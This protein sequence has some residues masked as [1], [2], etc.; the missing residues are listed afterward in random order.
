MARRVALCYRTEMGNAIRGMALAM[1]MTVATAS[2]WA[3]EASYTVPIYVTGNHTPTNYQIYVSQNADGSNAVPYLFD[4]GSP[5][6][7]TVQGT[8]TGITPTDSF[9]FG[10]G[11]PVYSYYVQ[12]QNLTLTTKTST[13]I[14]PV[15]SN[16]NTAMVVQIN[17]NEVPSNVPLADGT[18]GDFGAGFYG[19]S[20]LST[21]LTAIPLGSGSHLGYVVNVAGISSGT[22]SL[23]IGLT[24]ETIS[25]LTNAPGA[26]QL[27]MNHS[28]DQIQGPDGRLITGYL[29]GVAVTSVT[30]QTSSGPASQD[31]ATVFDTGGGP[32]GVIYYGNNSNP[33]D[34]FAGYLPNGS[35]TLSVP[36]GETIESWS[37]SSPWGGSVA[38]IGNQAP[39]ENRVNSGGYLFENYIVM[40]DLESAV[41]TL[42]PVPEPSTWALLACALLVV[43]PVA[44]RRKRR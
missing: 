17:G 24:P 34:A 22:G 2:A 20:T 33:P 6:M 30:V 11:N 1:G 10:D 15:V 19:T 25:T 37:G 4:T 31:L 5:N 21:L 35:F 32:N 29:K 44:S 43:L 16:F 39:S 26:I 41:L 38:V 3:Q 36:G 23:T 12:G 8:N 14:T 13:P 28:N 42:V 18:Y 7:F 27:H 40:Y 9:A